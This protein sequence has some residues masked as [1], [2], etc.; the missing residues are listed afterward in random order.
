MAEAPNEENGRQRPLS[1]RAAAVPLE[2]FRPKD[3]APSKSKA[4]KPRMVEPKSF[5]A[6]ER[7]WRRGG[8]GFC[9]AG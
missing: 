8:G 7:E 3:G 2:T 5:F 1:G 9:G 6:N 4:F